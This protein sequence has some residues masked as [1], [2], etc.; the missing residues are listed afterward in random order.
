MINLNYLILYS[1]SNIQ[2]YFEYI[3]KKHG[4]NTDKPSIEIYVNKIEN[5]V[6]FNTKNK[7]EIKKWV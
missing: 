2:D 3:F 4:E 6:T 1:L 5:G 7:K